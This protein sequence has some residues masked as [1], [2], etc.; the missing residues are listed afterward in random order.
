MIVIGIDPGLSGACSIL[1]HNGLRAVFDLPVMKIPSVGPKALVQNKI[2]GYT[3]CGLLLKH[4]PASEGRP[5]VVI[6]SVGTMGG[7]NNAVQ[8]QG[9]LLRSLGALETVA[10]CLKWPIEYAYPQTW[11]RFYGLVV[12]KDYN[13]SDSQRTSAAKKTAM[14]KARA[15]YPA[16]DDIGRVK[17]HNRA[18]AIL[19][20]HWW[21]QTNVS[22]AAHGLLAA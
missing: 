15:L 20:A 16:C 3:F 5:T 8:T 18:E 9:S 17:D 1:D 12:A 6:E 2:D 14:E 11:K 22:A 21:R 4:C 10:E 7:A 13:L 19:L